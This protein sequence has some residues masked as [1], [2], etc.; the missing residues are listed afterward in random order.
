MTRE[1]DALTAELVGSLLADA[2]QVSDDAI[3]A[4]RALTLDVVGVAV[5]GAATVEGRT[6]LETQRATEPPGN[7][8]I[9]V[10]E[11]R[12]SPATAALIT[13]TMAY[14]IGLTDTHAPSITHPGPSVVPA[15]L[16][17]GEALGSSGRDVLTSVILGVELVSR[18]GNAVNPSHRARGFHPTATC[19]HLG[20]ALATAYLLGCDEDQ[21]LSALGIAGSMSGGLYEFRHSG[22][23][24]M[25]LHGGWPAHGGVHAAYLAS[26]GFTGPH[27]VLE[28]PEGFLA[29]L[30]DTTQPDALVRSTGDDWLINELSFR[31]YCACRYAHSAID[32]L[33]ELK[34]EHGY[35]ADD[36]AAITVW[37]HRTAVEQEV[38]PTT[39]VSARLCTRFNVALAAIHGPR[40]TEVTQADLVDPVIADLSARTSIREDP[41][42]TAMFPA[43]WSCRVRL[44]LKSGTTLERQVDTAKGDPRN[45][46]T[47]SELE[48]KFRGLVVPAIGPDQAAALLD[49]LARPQTLNPSS[50]WELSRPRTSSPDDSSN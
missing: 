11:D 24:L 23:M 31:P 38:E 36:I 45:P 10:F 35:A 4:A 9:P 40:L 7:C 8:G 22:S 16:A 32:A 44:D 18:I 28:G 37:T 46:M 17:V 26:R 25:A 33:S 27:T 21:T 47:P 34:A 50:V 1:T 29:A 6:V 20:V 49:V 48:E 43:R 2:E 13:G 39:L 12:F 30:A 14:S 5:A 15:A 41:A 42:L 19:N 3:E